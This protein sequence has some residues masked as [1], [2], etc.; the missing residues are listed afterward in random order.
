MDQA[1]V[2]AAANEGRAALFRSDGPAGAS[3]HLSAAVACGRSS[4]LVWGLACVLVAAGAAVRP[5]SERRHRRDL[6]PP[7]RARRRRGR[8]VVAVRGRRTALLRFNGTAVACGRSVALVEGLPRAIRAVRRAARLR[9]LRVA[10]A[11]RRQTARRWAVPRRVRLQHTCE[12]RDEYRHIGVGLHDVG[13]CHVSEG[14][15]AASP[16]SSRTRPR[17]GRH[18]R[19][20]RLWRPHRRPGTDSERHQALSAERVQYHGAHRSTKCCHP[21][22]WSAWS[23]LATARSQCASRSCRHR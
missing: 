22:R 9:T 4:A 18:E 1:Y 10:S 11:S 17:V 13:Q 3:D 6:R 19:G 14:P 7:H 8:M 23:C 5:C 2:E 15:A 12:Q 16:R 21:L 20:Q